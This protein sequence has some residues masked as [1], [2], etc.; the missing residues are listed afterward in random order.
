MMERLMIV[1]DLD[2]D[3]EKII[4]KGLDGSSCKLTSSNQ[5]ISEK[6]Y[7]KG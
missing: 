4:L 1:M 5:S 3:H 2:D 6:T 7:S